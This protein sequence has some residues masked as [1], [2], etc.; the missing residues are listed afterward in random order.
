VEGTGETPEGYQ[1]TAISAV[2]AAKRI[3]E[4]SGLSG[5]QTPSTAFGAGFLET[6]PGCTLEIGTPTVSA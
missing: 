4:G 3:L 5:Y 2:E 1:L 6:L